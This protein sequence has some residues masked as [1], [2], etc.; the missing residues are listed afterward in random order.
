M[1]NHQPTIIDYLDSLE[2]NLRYY[3]T[4]VKDFPESDMVEMVDMIIRER[5]K[6]IRS[7]AEKG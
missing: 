7:L 4:R 5:L 2:G 6:A 3:L 1:S